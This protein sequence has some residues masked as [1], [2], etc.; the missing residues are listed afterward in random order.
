MNLIMGTSTA[1]KLTPKRPNAS[2]ARVWEPGRRLYDAVLGGLRTH[3]SLSLTGWCE[4][5][6]LDRNHVRNALLGGSMTD[7][8]AE[9]R[10]RAMRAAGLIPAEES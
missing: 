7:E 3:H 10:L 6:K 4:R 2:E 1:R 9:N 5:E 8:A